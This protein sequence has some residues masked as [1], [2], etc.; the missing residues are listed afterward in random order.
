MAEVRRVKLP[1][2]GVLHTF[3]TDDGGKVGVIAHRSGHSDLI[4]FSDED[5]GPGA[6]KISLRLSEDEAH[7]LAELLGG[8]QITESLGAL[9]QIPGLA[10]DWFSVDYDDHIAGQRLGSLTDHGVIGV[11]VVAVVRGDSANPAPDDSFK[12]FPGDTLVV[13]GSPEKVAKAFSF[14]RTGELRP[15]TATPTGP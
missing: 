5:G 8:T 10:I 2:V 6:R 4:T 12:V 9:E 15:K 13:A 11:T 1:G 7:T 3:V 14:Y